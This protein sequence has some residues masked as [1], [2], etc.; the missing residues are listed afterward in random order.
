MIDSSSSQIIV[1]VPITSDEEVV[2]ERYRSNAL[3]PSRVRLVLY[4]VEM[5]S[6]PL[7]ALRNYGIS[8]CDTS[9]IVLAKPLQIPSRIVYE[10]S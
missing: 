6:Y 3:Y 1:P 2:F 7:N 10:L 8:L 4:K 5:E 9:H